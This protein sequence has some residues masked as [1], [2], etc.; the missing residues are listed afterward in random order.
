MSNSSLFFS[1]SIIY[2][3]CYYGFT[4]QLNHTVT[5]NSM[6]D[7]EIGVSIR[8]DDSIFFNVFFLYIYISMPL[9]V[10]Q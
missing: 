9:E 3:Q 10:T 2:L 7:R 1:F 5:Q 8:I 6:T 4:F